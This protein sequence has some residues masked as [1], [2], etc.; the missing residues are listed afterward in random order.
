MK[1]K[2]WGAMHFERGKLILM[3]TRQ[4]LCCFNATIC[5]IMLPSKKVVCREYLELFGVAAFFTE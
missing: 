3:Q 4:P 1:Q 5:K 2:V